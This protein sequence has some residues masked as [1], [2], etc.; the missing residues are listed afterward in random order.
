MTQMGNRY[1]SAAS[2]INLAK[3]PVARQG[4]IMKCRVNPT[5]AHQGVIFC[6]PEIAEGLISSA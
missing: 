6:A 5:L 1:E 3:G 4:S 2:D